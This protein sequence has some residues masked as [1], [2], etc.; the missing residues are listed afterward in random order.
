MSTVPFI[1]CESVSPSDLSDFF[2]EKTE[3]QNI[4]GFLNNLIDWNLVFTA[5]NS[6]QAS[7]DENLVRMLKSLFICEAIQTFSQGKMNFVN[8]I[9]YDFLVTYNNLELKLE[10]KHGKNLFQSEKTN[11]TKN[12]KLDSTNGQS[13][14]HKKYVKTFDYLLLADENKSAIISYEDVEQY[15]KNDGDGRS[16]KIHKKD[17]TFF[18]E[19]SIVKTNKK[20]YL[21]DIAREVSRNSLK[22]LTEIYYK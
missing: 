19:C 17:L 6:Y 5:I 9:G 2:Q 3:T 1:K 14:Y 22:K 16:V 7:S 12:I 10:F 11:F 4:G 18:S 15:I 20:I 13:S 8:S 21:D